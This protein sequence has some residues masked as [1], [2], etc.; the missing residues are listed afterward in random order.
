MINLRRIKVKQKATTKKFLSFLRGF[1]RL[2]QLIMP[3]RL[4][5]PSK[6]SHGATEKATPSFPSATDTQSAN[7]QSTL[8]QGRTFAFKSGLFS[9]ML[10]LLSSIIGYLTKNI[11]CGKINKKGGYP[12]ESYFTRRRQRT[13]QKERYNKRQRRLRQKLSY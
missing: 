10:F 6:P 4:G 1:R 5:Q 7:T 3:R 2:F 13:R 11:L 9:F 12:Y 8:P